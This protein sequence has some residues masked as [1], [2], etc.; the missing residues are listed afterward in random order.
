MMN[1]WHPVF[2]SISEV[3]GSG[4]AMPLWHCA[5]ALQKTKVHRFA[6]ILRFKINDK[7]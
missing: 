5:A 2:L 3:K 1:E 6:S 4:S 7:E